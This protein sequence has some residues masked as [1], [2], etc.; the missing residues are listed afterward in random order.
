MRGP[1]KDILVCLDGSERAPKVLAEAVALAQRTQAKLHLFRSVG[2]PPE[3]DQ[4]LITRSSVSLLDLLADRAKSELADLAK[5]VPTE[6]LAGSRVRTGVPW[7]AICHEADELGADLI[8]VGSHGYSGL[9]RLLGT[10]AAKV[11]NHARCSV[12]VVR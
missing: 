3:V 12:L 9:D 2:L 10:T 7:D 6:I 1:M 11:V 8:V 5:T 4:E